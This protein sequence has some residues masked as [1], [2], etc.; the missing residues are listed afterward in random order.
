[1]HSCD[2]YL[3]YV[4]AIGRI[5]AEVDEEADTHTRDESGEEGLELAYSECVEEEEGERVAGCDEYAGPQRQAEQQSDGDGTAYHFLQVAAYDGELDHQEQQIAHGRTVLGSTQLC[6]VAARDHSQAQC[7][8][9][10]EQSVD[11]GPQQHPQQLVAGE[12]AGL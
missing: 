7:Q 9:L 12:G 3:G 4:D 1:M 6:Q 5:H 10:Q 8:Y 11:G 2:S